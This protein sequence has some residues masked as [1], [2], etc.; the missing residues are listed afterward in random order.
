GKSR[1]EST[2]ASV[3]GQLRPTVGGKNFKVF[4]ENVRIKVEDGTMTSARDNGAASRKSAIE[5]NKGVIS[6]GVDNPKGDFKSMEKS[7]GT[8]GTSA[9]MNARKALADVTNAQGNSTTAAKRNISKIKVS[10]GSAT[11]TVGI[12]LR[13]SCTVREQRNTSRGGVQ[14]DAPNRVGTGLRVSLGDQKN[15]SN[16]NGGQS[17]ATKD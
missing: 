10:G 9:N 8:Y 3:G 6:N 17:V 7:K 11:K 15:S 4:S 2:R 5:A 1:A 12:S 16:S 14:L 13:K